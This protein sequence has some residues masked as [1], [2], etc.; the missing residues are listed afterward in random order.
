MKMLLVAVLGLMLISLPAQ[1]WDDPVSVSGSGL[2]SVEG[3]ITGDVT[4]YKDYYDHNWY[5]TDGWLFNAGSLPHSATYDFGSPVELRNLVLW[6]WTGDA[7]GDYYDRGAKD[8]SVSFSDDGTTFS[9]E[10]A[11]VAQKAISS[12]AEPAQVFRFAPVTAQYARITVSSNYGHADWAGIAEARFND[13]FIPVEPVSP[14]DGQ[15]GVA[16]DTILEWAVYDETNISGYDVYFG[17]D[18]N[19]SSPSYDITKIVSNQTGTTVDPTP[20]GGLLDYSTT[21]YWQV[22]PVSSDPNDAAGPL[23]SFEVVAPSPVITDISPKTAVVGTGETAQFTVTGTNLEFFEWY[24]EGQ[25]TPLTNSGDISGADTA[26][27]TIANFVAADEGNYYCVVSNSLSTETA[28]SESAVL[29]AKRLVAQWAFNGSLA[30]SLGTWN[31]DYANDSGDL[32]DTLATYVE[33]MDGTANGAIAFDGTAFVDI[34]GSEESFQFHTS[35]LT[36]TAWV[37]NV[38]DGDSDSYMRVF[39]KAPEY[40]ICAHDGGYTYANTGSGPT[41]I[42]GD[43][44]GQWRLAVMT[45]DPAAG[46]LRTFGVYQND[47][48]DVAAVSRNTSTITLNAAA[49]PN[50]VRIGASSVLNQGGWWYLNGYHVDDVQIYNYPLTGEEVAQIYYDVTGLNICTDINAETLIGDLNGDCQVNLDDFAVIAGN[51]LNSELMY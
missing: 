32:D 3:L 40:E 17:T 33:G 21:Y 36:V 28:Q 16:R 18:P 31:G 11:F 47:G 8:F 30:D 22:V 37:K 5:G 12:N 23:W 20:S 44:A 34:P 39:S 41:A 35:G 1:A 50:V 43:N 42:L 51:W 10:V 7:G 38:A 25:A 2:Y 9:G 6:N 26:T 19:Q 13:P 29:M 4:S 45:Y 27:L 49:T 14:A 48:A 15:T 24:K 46:E